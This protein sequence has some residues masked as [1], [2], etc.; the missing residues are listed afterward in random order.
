MGAHIVVKAP[1]DVRPAI[2]QGGLDPQ[3]GKDAGELDR[4]IAAA[5]DQDA[6]RQLRQVEGLFRSDGVFDARQVLGYPGAAAG[7]DQDGFGGDG[8]VD[9]AVLLQHLDR[10]GVLQPG[11]AVDQLGARLAQIGDIDAGQ[12]GD[13]DVLGLEEALP[14]EGRALDVPAI[15][16]SDFQ[17][18]ADLGGHDH[19][20]L[21]HTAPDD[22]GAAHPVLLGDGHFL[23]RQ[24]R[25]PRRPH[26]ARAR[27]DD[28]EVV[29]VGRGHSGL[30]NQTVRKRPSEWS[31]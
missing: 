12:P 26:P 13:L 9:R 17:R 2:D 25:Q 21:G 10:V 7:G 30:L 20:F 22:T 31:E 11:A 6:L 27:T 15:A 23:A 5:R 28:K 3:T 19:E 14:V 1:Q 4:D 8:A 18:V 24:G 29:V 16:L